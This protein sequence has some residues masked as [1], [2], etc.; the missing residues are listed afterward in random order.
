M[1]T[2]T[3]QLQLATRLWALN[4]GLLVHHSLGACCPNAGA[5][6]CEPQQCR[7]FQEMGKFLRFL[8]VLSYCGP[9]ARAPFDLGNTPLGEGGWTTSF[10]LLGLNGTKSFQ[11]RPKKIYFFDPALTSPFAP[12]TSPTVVPSRA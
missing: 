12:L 10:D 2:G 4:L 6:L 11:I 3:K 7:I 8:Q 1:K 9:Q 5:R